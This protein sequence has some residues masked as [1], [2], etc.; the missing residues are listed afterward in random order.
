MCGDRQDDPLAFL[1]A[2]G[3]HQDLDLSLPSAFERE[4]HQGQRNDGQH[5]PKS[6]H[7]TKS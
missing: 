7:G 3:R 1:R 2:L 5:S 4:P 6:L